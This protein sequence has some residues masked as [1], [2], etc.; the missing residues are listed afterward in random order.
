MP[1]P[2]EEDGLERRWLAT[3]PPAY[4]HD[5]RRLWQMRA[6]ELARLRT[7]HYELER[8]LLKVHRG[9]GPH[10]RRPL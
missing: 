1:P 4:A 8:R 5:G 2:P 10:D 3:L 6:R 7:E 9:R